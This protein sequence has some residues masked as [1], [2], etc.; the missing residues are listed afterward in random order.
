MWCEVCLI[1]CVHGLACVCFIVS[2]KIRYVGFRWYNVR[3]LQ[4]WCIG[5]GLIIQLIQCQSSSHERVKLIGP[6]IEP[7]QQVKYKKLLTHSGWDQMEVISQTRF[8]NTSVKISLKFI[9][10]GPINNIPEVVQ[11][12]AWCRSG[13]KPFSEPMMPLPTQIPVLNLKSRCTAIAAKR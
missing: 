8:S 4:G 13:D 12:M 3:S 9:S 7:I 11:I 5:I 2:V 10:R 1:K 6:N